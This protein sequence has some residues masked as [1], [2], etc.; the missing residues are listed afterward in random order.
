M[1]ESPSDSKDSVTNPFPKTPSAP[2][3]NLAPNPF[4]ARDSPKAKAGPGP[5][6]PFDNDTKEK[7]SEKN[8]F[9]SNAPAS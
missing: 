1:K 4:D 8:P 5:S 3:P 2:S 6:N 7:D 9:T